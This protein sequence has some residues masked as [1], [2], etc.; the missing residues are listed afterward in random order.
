MKMSIIIF[1]RAPLFLFIT[2]KQ[3]AA[4]TI[5]WH[6]SKRERARTTGCMRSR[7]C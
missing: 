7:G 2:I 3:P 6:T 1:G 5:G 4:E